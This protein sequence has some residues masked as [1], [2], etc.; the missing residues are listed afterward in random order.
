MEEEKEMTIGSQTEL[1]NLPEELNT[2]KLTMETAGGIDKLYEAY[3]A[4][5]PVELPPWL[6]ETEKRNRRFTTRIIFV[7]KK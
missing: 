7:S 3:L 5:K 4:K 6:V 2:E 1:P